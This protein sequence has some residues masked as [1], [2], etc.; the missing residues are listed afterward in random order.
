MRSYKSYK[1]EHPEIKDYSLILSGNGLPLLEQ[2]D[3]ENLEN[4][5]IKKKK[6]ELKKNIK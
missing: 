4:E 2:S 6:E 5:D 1:S 3:K